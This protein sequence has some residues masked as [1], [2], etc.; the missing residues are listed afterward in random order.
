MARFEHRVLQNVEGRFY[1]DWSC[2][3]CALCVEVAP[4]VFQEKKE[5]GWAYVFNQPVSLEEV[6]AAMKAVEGCPT[7]SI[8][9]D[10]NLFDWR[11]IPP[12]QD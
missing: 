2:I 6:G 4:T 1:V 11:S 8:G 3:Y 7:E 12:M 9:F 10:G 5:E